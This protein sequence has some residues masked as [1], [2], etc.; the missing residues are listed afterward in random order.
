MNVDFNDIIEKLKCVS[1]P[2]AVESMAKYGITPENTFGVSIPNL[3]RIAKETGK[4]HV[5]AQ[6]LWK[7][8]FRET[9][10]LA[11]MVDEP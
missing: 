7:S 4:D 1:N 3:R 9:M 10:I 5:L 2:D 8:G 6:Q 11:S